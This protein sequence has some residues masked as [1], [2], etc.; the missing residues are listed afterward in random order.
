[1]SQKLDKTIK[2]IMLM[3]CAETSLPANGQND[4]S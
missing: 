1:M 3:C 2:F 4:V